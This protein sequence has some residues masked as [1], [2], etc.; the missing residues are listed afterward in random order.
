MRTI[1]W[2]RRRATTPTAAATSSFRGKKGGTMANYKSTV[3]Q[4]QH[5]RHRLAI[6]T[7][8]IVVH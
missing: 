8:V 6:S 5:Q 7:H 4:Q 3:K 2:D 1:T